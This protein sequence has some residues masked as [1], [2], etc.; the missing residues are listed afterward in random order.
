MKI[1][2][3]LVLLAALIGLGIWLWTIFFPSPEKVIRKQLLS[4]ADDV[5][6]T[7]NQNNLI[8]MA[9]AQS[10]ADFFTTN[11]VINITGPDHG[12]QITMSYDEITAA[13]LALRQHATDAT[14]KFPDI[15]VTVAPDKNSATADVTV[16]ATISGEP[17]AIL[18]EVKFGF[19]KDDGHWL[20]NHAETVQVISK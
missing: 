1:A 6:F 13:A 2:I 8:K 3:R 12:Q 9:H 18:Q 14:V 4:L 15:V 7:Q 10:V 19:E 20:I 16:D 11:V 17:D 5:S